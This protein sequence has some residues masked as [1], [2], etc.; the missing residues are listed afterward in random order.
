MSFHQQQQQQQISTP[1]IGNCPNTGWTRADYMMLLSDTGDGVRRRGRILSQS[2]RRCQPQ[3]LVQQFHRLDASYFSL[4]FLQF[5]M[6]FSDR[7]DLGIRAYNCP[8]SL[9]AKVMFVITA[10]LTVKRCKNSR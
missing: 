3:P 9:N 1:L 6:A 5:G 4:L 8:M 2:G 7:T 10:A